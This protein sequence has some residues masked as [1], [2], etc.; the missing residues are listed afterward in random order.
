MDTKPDV[1][2]LRLN[3]TPCTGQS[4]GN[5]LNAAMTSGNVVEFNQ[6]AALYEY[7]DYPLMSPVEQLAICAALPTDSSIDTIYLT[8]EQESSIAASVTALNIEKKHMCAICEDRA[9]GKH[10]GVYR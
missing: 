4:A 1:S 3:Q 6:D 7:I 10:Y 8:A 9:S 5:S 2:N